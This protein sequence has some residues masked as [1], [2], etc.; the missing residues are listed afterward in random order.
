MRRFL[1]GSGRAWEV[2]TGRE[3]WGTFVAIFLPVEEDQPV[4]QI[5]LRAVSHEGAALELEALGEADLVALLETAI[6][7]TP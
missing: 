5:P 1:D 4:R 6:P 7:M 2:V 3:S